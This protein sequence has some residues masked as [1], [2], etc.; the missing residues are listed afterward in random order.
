M[1]SVNRFVVSFALFLWVGLMP[2]ISYGVEVDSLYRVSV[3]VD[4]RSEAER[5]RAVKEGFSQVLVKTSG[6]SKVAGRAQL[7]SERNKANRYLIQFGYESRE[8][9]SQDLD[10]PETA[11]YLNLE[12]DPAAIN[13]L[14][15]RLGLPIWASNRPQMLL[16]AAVDQGSG[17]RL[18]GANSRSQVRSWVENLAQDRGLPLALPLMDSRDSNQISTGDVWGMFQKQI[19]SASQRYSPDVVLVAKLRQTRSSAQISAMLLLENQ[20]FWFDQSGNDFYT[21]VAQIMNQVSDKV[22]ET[23]AV[24]SSAGNQGQKVLLQVSAVD[25]LADFAALS[26][27]LEGVLAI[28]QAQ[29]QRVRGDIVQYLITLESNEDA[30]RQSFRLDKRLAPQAFQPV[31]VEPT[32]EQSDADTTPESKEGGDPALIDAQPDQAPAQPVLPTLSYKW[33]GA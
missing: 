28:R 7:A 8:L 4:D 23:Y 32:P 27:Y 22:A 20:Q 2:S 31:F 14:L 33:Q 21:V 17:R 12:Y 13:Q 16:W 19:N 5:N 30:L 9:P 15:R 24:V 25:Q 10:Q 29:V 11:I 6:S 18:L 1:S 3:K 26:S